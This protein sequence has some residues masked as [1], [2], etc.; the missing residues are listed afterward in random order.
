MFIMYL[1]SLLAPPNFIVSP[2]FNT[3]PPFPVT[4]TPLTKVPNLDPS[5]VRI[6]CC[7]K[8]LG[9]G[10]MMACRRLTDLSSVILNEHSRI[11]N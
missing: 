7:C 8:E 4:F 2:L 10:L 3:Q 9:L 1:N 6:N 11:Y 5:S